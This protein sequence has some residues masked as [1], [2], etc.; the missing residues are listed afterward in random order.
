MQKCAVKLKRP[1]SYCIHMSNP[2]ESDVECSISSDSPP[3]T[4]LD[5]RTLPREKLRATTRVT[6]PVP[7]RALG[8]MTNALA[9]GFTSIAHLLTFACFAS[10]N[11]QSYV[12]Q[13]N[14]VHANSGKTW[15]DIWRQVVLMSAVSADSMHIPINRIRFGLLITHAYTGIGSCLST[16]HLSNGSPQ[17]CFGSVGPARLAPSG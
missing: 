8:R 11:R 2:G 15:Q 6:Y 12:P 1:P 17:K 5:N 4:K 3:L 16:G 13:A 9:S 14:E 10:C 7:C